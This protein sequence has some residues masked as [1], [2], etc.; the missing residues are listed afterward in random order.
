ME[1]ENGRLFGLP[2]CNHMVPC[3]WKGVGVRRRCDGRTRSRSQN[4]RKSSEYAIM[5]LVLDERRDHKLRN[6]GTL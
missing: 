2:K 5:T 6:V 4:Q 3:K 1:F